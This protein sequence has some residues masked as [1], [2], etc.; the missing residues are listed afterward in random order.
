MTRVFIVKNY[1]NKASFRIRFENIA[2]DINAKIID[3]NEIEENINNYSN[4]IFIFPKLFD[5]NFLIL[6]QRLKNNNN[7][8][9]FDVC[10]NY[11]YDKI[12]TEDERYNFIK[13][14]RYA[15][16]ITCSSKTLSE[17]LIKNIPNL[18]VKIIEDS[19]EKIKS[20]GKKRMIKDF[21]KYK[22]YKIL[23][24]NYFK[25][26]WFGSSGNGSMEQILNLKKT[27]EEKNYKISLTIISDS[28]IEYERIFKDWKIK[29]SFFKWKDKDTMFNLIKLN[30][31]CIIPLDIN[32]FTICKTNNRLMQ[33][34]YLGLD[35]VADEI[36]SYTPFKKFVF[37]NNWSDNLDLL[38]KRDFLE[39]K[40]N[41][42]L[43][44][45]FIEE[46]FS[47]N[48]IAGKWLDLFKE[49]EK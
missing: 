24:K 19:F 4:N 18:R 36:P 14:L 38:Q 16:F 7:K 27:L 15:D 31:A 37:F 34:L 25:L 30:D 12:I 35:V 44:K 9:I 40:E 5:E 11:F 47:V 3:V 39:K 17:I 29:T 23:N 10:D 6:A 21:I 43:A 28:R 41:T 46:N 20:F 49:I 32:D 2:N 45:K 33:A 8:I 42:Q 22:K 26:V 13:M 48:K 1:R